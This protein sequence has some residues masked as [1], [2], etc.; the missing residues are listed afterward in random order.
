LR[1]LLEYAEKGNALDMHGLVVCAQDNIKRVMDFLIHQE[2]M[3]EGGEDP[4]MHKL[5]CKSWDTIGA[6]FKDMK[7]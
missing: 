3:R 4:E 1:L 2:I 5:W 7:A 6:F